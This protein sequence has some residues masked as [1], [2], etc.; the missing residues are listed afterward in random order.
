MLGPEEAKRLMYGSDHASL[1]QGETD[2]IHVTNVDAKTFAGDSTLDN[3][4][5][6]QEIMSQ[7]RG[8]KKSTKSK[9]SLKNKDD[10]SVTAAGTEVGGRK[11]TKNINWNSTR[12]QSVARKKAEVEQRDTDGVSSVG[13]RSS[14]SPA[15]LQ[16]KL[17]S[18]HD[19]E[20][21]CKPQNLSLYN[22]IDSGFKYNILGLFGIPDEINPD[23]PCVYTVL[24]SVFPPAEPYKPK[25]VNSMFAAN[26]F[27][28]IDFDRSMFATQLF[29]QDD[30][31]F[32]ELSGVILKL[33]ENST[34]VYDIKKMDLCTGEMTDYGFA[35]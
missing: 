3:Q 1:A 10:L 30:N 19:V 34:I 8:G 32:V 6:R 9:T 21:Y 17:I 25:P 28:D 14:F 13:G 31:D 2:A 35:V 7:A 20:R 4:N 15:K 11:K 29:K 12:Q 5:Q 18:I 33:N 26:Y 27:A 16:R 22:P 24:A 23:S